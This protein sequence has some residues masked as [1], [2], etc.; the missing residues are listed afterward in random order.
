MNRLGAVRVTGENAS[1]NLPS[2]AD[3]LADRVRLGRASGDLDRHECHVV[4]GQ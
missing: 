1:G 4:V 2:V 3:L